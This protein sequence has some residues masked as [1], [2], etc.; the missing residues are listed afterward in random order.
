MNGIVLNHSIT[1]DR[2]V[3]GETHPTSSSLGRET[4]GLVEGAR[5]NYLSRG[6]VQTNEHMVVVTGRDC[7][8]TDQDCQYQSPS[9]AVAV[10][11]GLPDSETGKSWRQT[12]GP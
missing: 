10:L 1:G 8:P 4:V 9:M 5:T 6:Q 3:S 2:K 12:S 7:L 11:A